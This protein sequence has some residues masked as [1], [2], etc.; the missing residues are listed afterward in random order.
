MLLDWHKFGPA[1]DNIPCISVL[2][3]LCNCIDYRDVNTN[4]VLFVKN[5]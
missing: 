3:H 2:T 4:M 5:V 1:V